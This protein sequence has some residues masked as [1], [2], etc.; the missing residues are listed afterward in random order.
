MPN[1]PVLDLEDLVQEG[2]KTRLDASKSYASGG[3]VI[4]SMTIKPSLLSDAVDVTSAQKLD[5][6]YDFTFEVETGTNDS[7]EFNEAGVLKQA[8]L[9]EGEY[10][11]EDMAAQIQTA[12][13]AVSAI[14]YVVS[15]D[16]DNAFTIE[17]DG[18]TEFE[19]LPL[20]GND[21]A[22]SILPAI[23][24]AEDTDV[25]TSQESEAVETID[26]VV[27]L[28]LIQDEDPDPDTEV[29]KTFILPVISEAADHLFSSDDNLRRHEEA[30][31]S[32][33]PDGRSTW[34]NAHRRAQD[35]IITWLDDNGYVGFQGQRI[36][37]KRIKDVKEV[38]DWA[39]FLTLQLIFENIRNAVDDVFGL[40]VEK[41]ERL[42]PVYRNKA[43]LRMD[44]NE[45][46]A[47]DIG[48]GYEI[49]SAIVVR[50]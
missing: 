39:T 42:V 9:A 37:P 50:R 34:K 29:S 31:M 19:L 49:R 4:D 10:T 26:K 16:E 40:K 45:D 36:T 27:T 21:P 41:Y 28:T 44:V 24:F 11:P 33:V 30:I 7:L 23:G 6:Q 35:L 47:V 18:S 38:T 43:L 48:E 46:G 8:T 15:V 1:F 32:Y 25:G 13:R 3:S 2:D 22:L 5:W 12:M 17:S 20:G 14:D